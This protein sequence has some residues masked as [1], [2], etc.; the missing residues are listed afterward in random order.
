MDLETAVLIEY[1]DRQRGAI[2]AKVDGLPEAA[3]RRAVLPSGWNCLGLI[4]HLA[5][6]VER[7][8]FRAIAVGEDVD[9]DDQAWQV[10]PDVPAED[11][12]ELYR[13]EIQRSNTIVATMPL[14]AM[15]RHHGSFPASAVVNLRYIVLHVIEETARHAGHLDIARELLDG[16]TGLT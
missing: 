16:S 4:Q 1:L 7:Y 13:E 12:L 9:L 5:L 15:A 14:D 6:D 10:K 3:L 2:L 11:I 8:W